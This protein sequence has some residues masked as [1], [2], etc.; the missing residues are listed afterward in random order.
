[1]ALTDK[2]MKRQ[3]MDRSKI[4]ANLAYVKNSQ[5]NNDKITIKCE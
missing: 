5:L 3:T 2:G 1:M 4:F